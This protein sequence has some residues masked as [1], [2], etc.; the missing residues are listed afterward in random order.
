MESNTDVVLLDSPRT[1]IMREIGGP[2][3]TVNDPSVDLTKARGMI[4]WVD[5]DV[6]V[7]NVLKEVWHPNCLK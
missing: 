6:M 4:L 5:Q 3:M 1:H 7:S 2:E